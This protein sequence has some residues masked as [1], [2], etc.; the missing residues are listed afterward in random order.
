MK[1]FETWF[2]RNLD[3]ISFGMACFALGLSL[4]AFFIVVK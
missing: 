2:I 4:A 1:K 3:L